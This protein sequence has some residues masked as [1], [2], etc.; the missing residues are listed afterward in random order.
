[1]CNPAEKMARFEMFW[2]GSE[3]RVAD[4]VRHMRNAMQGAAPARVAGFM[5]SQWS[6]QLYVLYQAWIS[7]GTSPV[8]PSRERLCQVFLYQ[9]QE[10]IDE[11]QGAGPRVERRQ[12]IGNSMQTPGLHFYGACGVWCS[13]PC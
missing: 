13:H 11:V 1:M 3:K 4:R 10:Y 5:R 7:P 8:F 2:N 9:A 6:V 12:S